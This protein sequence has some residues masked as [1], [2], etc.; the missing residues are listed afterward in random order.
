MQ[1]TFETF[2]NSLAHL[3]IPVDRHEEYFEDGYSI[4]EAKEDW[5]F[6][7]EADAMAEWLAEYSNRIQ[8]KGL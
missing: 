3:G 2:S 1:H 6:Q 8:E 7:K 5:E 4:Q